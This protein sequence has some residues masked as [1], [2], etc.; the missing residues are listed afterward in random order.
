MSDD[1]DDDSVTCE[2]HGRSP[3]TYM[4]GHLAENPVQRWHGNVRTPDNAW[5]DAWCDRCNAAFLRDGEWTD[6]NSQGL[7]LKIFCC[8]CY[9]HAK[10]RSVTRLRGA[11]LESWNDL[12]ATC[13]I[14]LQAKQ[15]VLDDQFDIGHHARWDWNQDRAEIVFSNDGVPAVIA[16]VAFVGSVSDARRHV[17]VVLGQRQSVARRG[18]RDAPGARLRRRP[19]SAAPGRSPVAGGTSTTAGP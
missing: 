12:V 6:E 7:N 5:P 3:A 11:S 17:A 8:G 9:E 15:D 19:G 10:G 2:S 16:S 4:C 1:A 13:R 14:E 18:R